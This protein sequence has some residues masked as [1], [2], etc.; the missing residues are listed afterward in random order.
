MLSISYYFN[1]KPNSEL[2]SWARSMELEGFPGIGTND[3]WVYEDCNP[4]AWDDEV[5][6][7]AVKCAYIAYI[8]SLD[9][10]P[11]ESAFQ[12]SKELSGEFFDRYW[13]VEALGAV[14]EDLRLTLIRLRQDGFERALS[15]TGNPFILNFLD[16]TSKTV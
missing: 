13:E 6:L 3:L 8:S 15:A 4:N 16:T 2:K 12:K 10:P 7:D 11:M 14:N 1:I 9:L 5:V